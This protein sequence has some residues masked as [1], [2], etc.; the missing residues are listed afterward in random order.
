MKR[1]FIFAL[2]LLVAAVGLTVSFA[3]TAPLDIDYNWCIDPAVWGDDRC[4]NHDDPDLIFCHWEVGW[5][6]PGRI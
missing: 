3:E 5:Y 1:L 2:L 4:D 6:M